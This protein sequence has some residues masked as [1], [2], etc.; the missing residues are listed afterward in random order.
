MGQTP[1][2]APTASHLPGPPGTHRTTLSL[3]VNTLLAAMLANVFAVALALPAVM[4][5]RVSQPARHVQA[6]ALLQAL[7]WGSFMLAR[8]VHDRLFSTL[9]IALLGSSFVTT[10]RALHGWLGPR[11]G[12]RV[13]MAAAVLTPVGYGLGFD[14]YAF[15]VG[16]SNAGLALQMLIVCLACAWPAPHAS[17]RWRGLVLISLG[18]LAA[19][20]LA[21]GVLGAFFTEL[22]PEL[23]TPHPINL[24]G[25]VLNLVTIGLVTVGMLI[26]WHE[27]ADRELRRQADTDPLTGLLNRRAW[28]LRAER[29]LDQ[30]RRR[31]AGAAL[32][33][34]DVDHF[35]RINDRW[36][37][38]TGDR[39]L[40]SVARAL[41][42]SARRDDLVC[43]YGGEEFCLL[44]VDVDARA[45]QDIDARLR[46]ALH[47]SAA[48][49]DGLSLAFSSGL[50]ILRAGDDVESLLRRADTAL[51]EAKAAGRGRLV[52]S[53]PTTDL[54]SGMAAQSPA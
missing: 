18:A 34:I 31:G 41:A 36:G 11:P 44:L 20:T 22:Y 19:V 8:P 12:R 27:E 25:A 1:R 28:Q 17:R 47:R 32:L 40:Q 45:C 35:K 2:A 26:G 29:A 30:V 37:H 43:R 4:G 6:T 13:L 51:Y 49:A 10:W 16:W 24:L 38:E 15:R 42:A 53:A 9:W 3:D 46:H 23:R 33:M 14:D 48:L 52:H 39:A 5:W 7:A 54:D 50:A 21:R